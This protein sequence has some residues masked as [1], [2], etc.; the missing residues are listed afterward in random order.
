MQLNIL[1]ILLVAIRGT[2]PCAF[3]RLA[4]PDGPH[5]DY[6]ARNVAASQ[7]LHVGTRRMEGHGMFFAAQ[8]TR[9]VN[10]FHEKSLASYSRD[11][12]P[13]FSVIAVQSSDRVVQGSPLGL[14]IDVSTSGTV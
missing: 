10:G 11:R 2:A 6:A 5:E 3:R 8:M 7:R 12:L 13:E 1:C 9:R 14:E 4:W